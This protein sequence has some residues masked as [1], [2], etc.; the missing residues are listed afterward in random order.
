MQA[1]IVDELHLGQLDCLSGVRDEVTA[2]SCLCLRFRWPGSVQLAKS[3]DE[4][5][6]IWVRQLT[7]WIESWVELSSFWSSTSDLLRDC[8][9]CYSSE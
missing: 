1:T 4:R 2:Y 5:Y 8:L 9:D 7:F 3:P 6:F